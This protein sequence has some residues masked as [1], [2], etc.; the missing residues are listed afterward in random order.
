MLL[1]GIAHVVPEKTA[2]S[3]NISSILL[4]IW[5]AAITRHPDS[6]SARDAYRSVKA[7]ALRAKEAKREVG[8]YTA[9]LWGMSSIRRKQD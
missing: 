8:A 2:D 1:K 9:E 5:D 6:I 4:K 3:D 7:I